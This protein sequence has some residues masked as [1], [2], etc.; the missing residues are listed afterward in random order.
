MRFENKHIFFYFENTLAYCTHL[1]EVDVDSV[2]QLLRL[3]VLRSSSATLAAS[4]ASRLALHWQHGDASLPSSQHVTQVP[5]AGSNWSDIQT[6]RQRHD[7]ENFFAEIM[8][9]LTHDTAT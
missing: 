9:F 5:F 4:Q 1:G 6:G 8:A 7:F 2:L 3:R